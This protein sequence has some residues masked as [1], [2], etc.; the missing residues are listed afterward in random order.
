MRFGSP[1]IGGAVLWTL[2]AA[3]VVITI[4]AV[5]RAGRRRTYRRVWRE[6]WRAHRE[7]LRNGPGLLALD[8]RYARG[9][10]GRDDYLQRRADLLSRR[11]L[12]ASTAPR[13]PA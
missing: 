3:A 5:T 12:T 11:P 7:S 10:I 2:L 8:M 6:E 9:E 1:I 4:V 13:S